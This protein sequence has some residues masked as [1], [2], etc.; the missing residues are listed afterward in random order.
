MDTDS[1]RQMIVANS[2][3]ISLDRI[4]SKQGVNLLLYIFNGWMIDHGMIPDLPTGIREGMHRRNSG[5][6]QPGML[7]TQYHK[8]ENHIDDFFEFDF[9]DPAALLDGET[10]WLN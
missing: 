2:D 8:W 5:V 7:Y 10:V 3:M 4:S 1:K 9:E 6:W